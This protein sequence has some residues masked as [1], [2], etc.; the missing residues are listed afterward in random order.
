MLE[1][2]EQTGK[3]WAISLELA[4]RKGLKIEEL[5]GVSELRKKEEK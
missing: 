1:D 4:K 3:S 5:L 2:I